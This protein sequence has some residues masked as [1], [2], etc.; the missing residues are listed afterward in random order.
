[1]KLL[2]LVGKFPQ[3]SETFIIRKAICLSERGHHVLVMS[4]RRGDKQLLQSY[5]PLPDNLK[6][7]YLIPEYGPY[8]LSSLCWSIYRVIFYCFSYPMS[9]LKLYHFLITS[10]RRSSLLRN[11]IKFLPFINKREWDIIHAEFL[12]IGYSYLGI[13]H[14]LNIKYFVSSR[15]SEIN[16]IEINPQKHQLVKTLQD[17]DGIHVVSE[18]M[19]DKIIKLGIP[20][21]KILVN[22]PAINFSQYK[23]LSKQETNIP[24]ILSVGRLV[25]IKG[26]D[27]LL[28]SFRLLKDKKISFRAVI[29]GDGPLFSEL[30]YSISDLQLDEEVQLIGNIPPHKV[31]NWLQKAS[32][33]VLSSHEEGISNAALEAMGAGVAVVSTACGGMD[34]VIQHRKNGLLVPIRNPV[35]LSN[36][37]GSLL[38]DPI[39]RKQL[40]KEARITIENKF[41]L[42][43]QTQMFEAFYRNE[44]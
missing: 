41:D 8:S 9:A 38:L 28:E 33:F 40:G 19:L 39:R 10:S 14:L 29:I 44:L 7:E 25:W 42:S 13:K 31:S 4:R 26:L 18:K 1:M 36:E 43:R 22:R 27:Y 12:G 3:L 15:G 24:L 2:L 16:T 32:I 5:Y 11:W 30:Q 35:V 20:E 37:L 21:D 34:E 17:C 6:I 23:N